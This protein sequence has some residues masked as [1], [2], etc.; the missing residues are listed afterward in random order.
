[1]HI[2]V[3]AGH[4]EVVKVLVAAALLKKLNL[5][6]TDKVCTCLMMCYAHT[7][8]RIFVLIQ[9]GMTPLTL[10]KKEKKDD[11]KR[12]LMELSDIT[13][14]QVRDTCPYLSLIHI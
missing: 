6:T 4:L 1:M 11:I 3:K 7:L 14:L 12:I 2:A 9:K 8:R 5:N 10:A 13:I